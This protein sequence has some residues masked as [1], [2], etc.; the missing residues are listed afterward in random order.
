MPTASSSRLTRRRL[1]LVT[2]IA[3]CSVLLAA[4]SGA[5][6]PTAA[7]SGAA[8]PG[9]TAT[10]A[11]STRPDPDEV[12]TATQ[13]PGATNPV[14]AGTVTVEIGSASGAKEYHYDKVTLQEP[15]GSKIKLKFVNHTDSK[16]EV[17]HNWVLVKPGQEAE[18]MASSK[19]AGDDND[20][21]NVDDPAVLAHTRLI[22]GGQSNTITFT[23]APGT[24]TYLCTFPG[25]YAAGE[26]GTLVIK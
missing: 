16:D 24:Y 5:A 21:L 22:E 19:A 23:A 10:V 6:E 8:S 18:V 13:D 4:C 1:Q 25:H 14:T 11:S 26:K 12:G 3:A 17:G 15:A 2:G 7:P 20:W 9:G